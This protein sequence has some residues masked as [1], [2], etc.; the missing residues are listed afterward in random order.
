MGCFF[1]VN[2]CRQSP[3]NQGGLEKLGLWDWQ[4][5][6]YRQAAVSEEGEV[7]PAGDG[8]K[9]GWGWANNPRAQN[10]ATR[11]FL[12]QRAQCEYFDIF[13]DIDDGN[14]WQL[15]AGQL[16]RMFCFLCRSTSPPVRTV[17]YNGSVHKLELAQSVS[18]AIAYVTMQQLCNH[19][20]NK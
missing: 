2:S 7:M 4:R 17:E 6:E 16:P 14:C 13:N 8:V 10:G 1:F 12:G 5:C 18:M 11:T 3:K 19:D 9:G 15:L 20:S